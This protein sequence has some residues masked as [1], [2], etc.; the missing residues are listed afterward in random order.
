MRLLPMQ[1]GDVVATYA[2]TAALQRDV[3][4]SPSTPIEQGCS[5]F[6]DWYRGYYGA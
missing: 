4:F 6:A 2:D 3:G 1:A 5:R